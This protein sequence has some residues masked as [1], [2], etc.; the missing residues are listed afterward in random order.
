MPDLRA[1]LFTAFVVP[2]CLLA[3]LCIFRAA[4]Q[5][6]HPFFLFGCCS[7]PLLK[8]IYEVKYSSF[9]AIA[10]ENFY[11]DPLTERELLDKEREIQS[12]LRFEYDRSRTVV[13]SFS[14]SGFGKGDLSVLDPYVWGSVQAYYHNNRAHGAVREEWD[15]KGLYVNWWEAEPLV[16]QMPWGLKTMWHGES[17]P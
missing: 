9:Y 2:P 4:P 13:R 12:T 6:S 14:P 8:G 7:C 11:L 16:L 3:R 10:P 15:F 17:M 1:A 5:C